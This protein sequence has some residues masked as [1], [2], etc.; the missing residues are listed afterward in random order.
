MEE[1]IEIP[2][3]RRGV[4]IWR[5]RALKDKERERRVIRD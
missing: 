4:V 2:R 5:R 1:M 3:R